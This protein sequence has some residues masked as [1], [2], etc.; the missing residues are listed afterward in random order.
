MALHTLGYSI[1]H[2]VM[3]NGM[4][5]FDNFSIE[6]EDTLR[7]QA[8]VSPL[9]DTALAMI[10]LLDGGLEPDHPALVQAGRWLLKE[11]VLT[12]GDWQVKTKNLAPGGWA[13]EFHNDIYPDVDDTAEIVMALNRI[14]LP[15]DDD[16]HRG[17]E[18]AVRWLLGM[19]SGNG[20]WAAFDKD[21]TKSLIAMIPFADFGEA[22]DP[23]SGDVTGHVLEMLG[24][25]GY[26][27]D[28][29]AVAK[30]L[31]YLISEQEE[32]GPWF[33][34]WGVNY[35]Y[36]TGAVLPAL[37]SLGIDVNSDY[38]RRAVEWVVDHQNPDGG[39]GESCASY[40]DADA[41]G[42]GPSTPSQTG[43]TILALLAAGEATHAATAQGIKYLIDT[44][45][46]DGSWDEPYFTG[47]GF[48]GYGVGRR[49]GRYLAPDDHGYQGSELPAGFMI[50]YHMYRNYWPLMAL[51]RYRKTLLDGESPDRE[52]GAGDG[53]RLEVSRHTYRGND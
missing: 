24:Q 7:V 44:Q 18:R 11:Q 20:G 14:R 41:R 33:G 46:G 12:G 5:G 22:L 3:T 52:H 1:D 10:G 43:W 26:A 6:E 27:A 47:T 21:N 48:P 32:D 39:W 8:C 37:E 50:N 30:A 2:P 53:R 15:E 29:P 42:V 9:W 35:T 19:Q 38:V 40:V 17:I 36:G 23:P 13:F 28:H 25:L 34:R 49:L 16:R 4:T 31:D 45:Q 51:G